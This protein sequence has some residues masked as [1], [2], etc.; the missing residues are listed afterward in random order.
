M[1]RRSIKGLSNPQIVLNNKVL[2]IVPN[3]Y[4][5]SLGRGETTH[6]R[7]ST[8]GTGTVAVISRN[9]ETFK[10][11]VKF[12]IFTTSENKDIIDTAKL[13][14]SDNTLVAS[15]NGDVEVFTN[16]TITNDPEFA[17]GNDTTVSVEAEADPINE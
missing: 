11:M 10:S 12:E 7:A 6:R 8:G 1:A 2:G 13:N 15:E 4:T 9:A 16:F 3:S 5:S 17:R 14:L